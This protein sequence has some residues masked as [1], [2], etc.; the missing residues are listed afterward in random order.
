MQIT[1]LEEY[2]PYKTEI[3]MLQLHASDIINQVPKG[4]K[5][6]ELGCG[7]ATKTSV[8]LRELLRRYACNGL[9]HLLF[10]GL[11]IPF[12]NSRS[13]SQVLYLLLNCYCL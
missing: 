6:V 1:D 5:V 4:A 13:G 2:Y 9:S 7:S 8:L 3:Q 11:V 12:K 10:S